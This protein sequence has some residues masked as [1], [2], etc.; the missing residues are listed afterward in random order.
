[1]SQKMKR[2]IDKE[3]AHAVK[4]IING[5]KIRGTGLKRRADSSKRLATARMV[6]KEQKI[7]NIQEQTFF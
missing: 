2:T 6:L 3:T 5:F 4:Q 7:Q 1:M